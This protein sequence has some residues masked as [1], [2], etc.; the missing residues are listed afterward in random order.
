MKTI[1]RF[2]ITLLCLLPLLP[3]GVQAEDFT[4]KDATGKVHNLADY[5]GKW[6]LVNFW[7]TWCPPCLE[8][9]PDLVALYEERKDV[10]V[11]GIAMDYKNPKTVLEFADSMFVT[12]P[13]VLGDKN[14][15]AKI[16]KVPG[17]PTTYLF[18]PAGKQAAY[19]VGRITRESIENFMQ[20]YSETSPNSAQKNSASV[21]GVALSAQLKK[22]LN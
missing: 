8:E 16:G 9:M 6:V 7:A 3:L 21:P 11:L 2:L 4:L 17:L 14:I 13:I 22:Q 15:A 18:D 12:Y 20:K 19:K 1:Q 10:M 5:K